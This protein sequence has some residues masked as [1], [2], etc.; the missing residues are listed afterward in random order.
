MASKIRRAPAEK[1]R[2]DRMYYVYIL[3]C[4]DDTHYTGCTNDIE[5]RIRRHYCGEIKYTKTRLPFQLMFYASFPD[6]YKAYEFEKYL[7]TG[8]GRAFTKRHLL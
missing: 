7:K 5:D 3:K 2:Q 8:S 4:N 6:E 1:L